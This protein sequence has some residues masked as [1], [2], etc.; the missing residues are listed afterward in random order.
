MSE[1]DNKGPRLDGRLYKIARRNTPEIL[2]MRVCSNPSCRREKTL[3][4][5][6]LV[7]RG[8]GR[9]GYLC[10]TCRAARR[11]AIEGLTHVSK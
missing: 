2:G 4:K 8:K 9:K 10:D 11:K 5:F 6:K 3:D 1:S 7:N